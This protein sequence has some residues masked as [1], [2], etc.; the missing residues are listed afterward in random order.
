M[1]RGR[2]EDGVVTRVNEGMCRASQA[3]EGGETEN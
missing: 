2:W 1:G 3:G